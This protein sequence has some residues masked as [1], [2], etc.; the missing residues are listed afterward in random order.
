[1]RVGCSQLDAWMQLMDKELNATTAGNGGSR[2]FTRSTESASP[3]AEYMTVFFR[4]AAVYQN[5]NWYTRMIER[6]TRQSVL[7]I[8]IDGTLAGTAH[9]SDIKLGDAVEL[10]R[11]D[12]IVDLGY[13]G[14]LLDHIPTTFSGVSVTVS[15]NKTANDRVK[16]L[17]GVFSELSKTQPPT[18]SVS[19]QTLGV[20][21][22]S[23][24]FADYLF[25]KNLLVKKLST[26]SALPSTGL[27]PAG[28]YAVL[29]GDSENDYSRYL[30]SSEEQS[31]LE[32]KDGQLL[33]DKKPLQ[34]LSYFV[35]EIG[36]DKR[37]FKAPLDFLSY[38]RVKPAAA[39]FEVARAKVPGITSPS[40]VSKI[41]D[42]IRSN[43][44]D[45]R[46]LLSQDP[47]YI[48]EEKKDIEKAVHDEIETDLSARLGEL[49]IDP[50]QPLSEPAD[51][52]MPGANQGSRTKSGTL[53]SG[54]TP[55]KTDPTPRPISPPPIIPPHP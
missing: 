39:L 29:A 55:Q 3:G 53:F 18:L 11:N 13:S 49:N 7:S 9:I 24:S 27:L 50:K 23:K 40:V 30:I 48:E 10:R 15:L 31:G 41:K 4:K 32:W 1:M 6:N 47:D 20:V 25:G 2:C 34:R 44:A 8:A 42:E 51:T 12:A 33:Y 37:F 14:V 36:Y 45:A 5:S 52:P 54:E 21:T 28:V 19:Q 22:A 17:I 35:I 38:S 43:L 26:R 16:E 46:H